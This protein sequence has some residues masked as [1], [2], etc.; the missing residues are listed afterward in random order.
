M[1]TFGSALVDVLREIFASVRQ[2][3]AGVR[4]R[5]KRGPF[6]PFARAG[7]TV[8]ARDLVVSAIIGDMLAGRPVVYADFLGYDEVAHHTGIE[9]FDALA[10]IRAI[11]QQ[12][13]RL[14]RAE[15]LAP[16]RYQLVVLS[17]HGVTQGWAFTNRF[18]ESVQQLV[19][20]LCGGDP[21]ANGT[22]KHRRSGLAAGRRDG[23]GVHG[24]G[25]DRQGCCGA[26]R[27]T[28]APDRHR[29]EEGQPAAVARVPRRAWSW[30]CPDMS[31]WCRSPSTPAG[32]TSRPSKGST[33][34]CCRRSRPVTTRFLHRTPRTW[35]GAGQRSSCAEATAQGRAR[36]AITHLGH[37]HAGT[38]SRTESRT[39]GDRACNQRL[40]RPPTTRRRSRHVTVVLAPRRPRRA[41]RHPHSSRQ[42]AWTRL[43]QY[44]GTIVGVR[45]HL[46][47]AWLLPASAIAVNRNRRSSPAGRSGRATFARRP[48]AGDQVV[49][50]GFAGDVDAG[51]DAQFGQDVGHVG[52]DGARGEDQ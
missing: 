38:D 52:A 31:R 51:A 5:V 42:R 8:I 46:A 47:D 26:V 48:S 12:I 33:P 50:G 41:G 25:P 35:P 1:R 29:T 24:R 36:L 43:E 32:S 18:G 13:G 10:V 49:A 17:D 2:K 16:R 3:R 19:G 7:T 30:W 40:L 27:R 39:T 9:R 44:D 15:R 21:P 22:R 6:F 23:R 45:L 37:L 28:Y 14:Y 11:D 20:R 34:T 4:P